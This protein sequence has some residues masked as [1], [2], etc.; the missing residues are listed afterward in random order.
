MKLCKPHNMT[1]FIIDLIIISSADICKCML[2]A[3]LKLFEI[4]IVIF[5]SETQNEMTFQQVQLYMLTWW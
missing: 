1:L 3:V 5:A 2:N 4:L